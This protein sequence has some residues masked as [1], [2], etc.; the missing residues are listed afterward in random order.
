MAAIRSLGRVKRCDCPDCA[1]QTDACTCGEVEPSCLQRR[2]KGSEAS[3]I[4]FSEFD[5]SS[6]P[7]KFRKGVVDVDSEQQAEI[8]ANVCEGENPAACT[9]LRTTIIGTIEINASGAS[10]SCAEKKVYSNDTPDPDCTLVLNDTLTECS[11]PG[12]AEIYCGADGATVTSTTFEQSTSLE[13]QFICPDE[14]L[15]GSIN[16][17]CDASVTLSEEDTEADAIT[18]LQAGS[19]S[20]WQADGTTFWQQRT[21]GFSFSYREAEWRIN[22]EGLDAS[23][24]YDFTIEY[25]RRPFGGD[26]SSWVLYSSTDLS[27]TTDGSG[28]LVTTGTTIPNVAGY[29]TEVRC[30]CV[31]TPT[32]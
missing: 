27:A 11:V 14:S 2:I 30:D 10:I 15:Y 8:P 32:P 6:P 1:D 21:S 28:N 29:E 18:R 19:W 25:W 22:K 20:D 24:S 16:N 7:K 23:T 4:G 5:P 26:E 3:L 17:S 12:L 31:F 9:H 13:D